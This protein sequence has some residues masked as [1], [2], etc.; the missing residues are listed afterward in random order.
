MIIISPL[1]RICL[2]IASIVL[3]IVTLAACFGGKCNPEYMTLP[4][5][6]AL[7]TPYLAISTLIVGIAWLLSGRILMGALAGL[8][9]FLGWGTLKDVTP[10]A[11]SKSA[12]DEKRTFR[13]MT[14]NCLHLADTTMSEQPGN[15]AIEF[16]IKSDADIICLQELINF[17]DPKEIHHWSR[18]MIDSLYAA[19]PYRAGGPGTSYYALD[20]KVLSKYPIVELPINNNDS[21]E[22]SYWAK[23]RRWRLFEVDINGFK[24]PLVDFHMTS[25]DLTDTEREV[26][27]EIRGVD[28][29]KK[30][31]K[32][33]RYE[34][35]PKLGEAFR[36]RAKN[37]EEMIS[38]TSDLST[39]IACGDFNDVPGSWSYRLMRKAGFQDAYP[40]TSL[41][42][43]NTFNQFL[44]LFHIDQIFYRGDHLKAIKTKRHRIN[45]SDHYPV[46]ATFEILP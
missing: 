28:T 24:L 21:E 14:F 20:L 32:E 39:L 23:R 8:T 45:T 15:R 19:Y 3:F 18:G 10:I 13:L 26:V 5:V 25:Y 46:E 35:F 16:L 6:L 11:F 7:A 12:Q 33:F 30:S 4:S 43:T 1:I 36:T 44:F 34:I 2:K 40:E 9:L 29:A 22:D 31:Y 17:E 42:P 27:T 41:G 37:V 38:S